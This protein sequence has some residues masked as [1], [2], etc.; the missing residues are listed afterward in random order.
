MFVAEL[1]WIYV[2]VNVGYLCMCSVSGA[3]TYLLVLR[4]M[5]CQSPNFPSVALLL[6]RMITKVLFT[7]FNV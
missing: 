2:A 5:K 3:Y 4:V 7:L 6:S 1:V